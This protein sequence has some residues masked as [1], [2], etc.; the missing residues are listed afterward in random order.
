MDMATDEDSDV[1]LDAAE[2]IFLI[3]LSGSMYFSGNAV[4]L[5]QAALKIFLHSLPEGSKFNIV[6]FGSEYV[7]TFPKSVE[8][9]EETLKMAL[10]DVGQY[11][12]RNRSLGGT[13][14]Y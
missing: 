10:E 14:V 6:A 4:V 13:E 9:N 2:F 8:Y 3:D 7:S 5:A 11:H 1:E 12:D